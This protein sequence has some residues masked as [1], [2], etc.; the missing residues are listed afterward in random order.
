M[1]PL[2]EVKS[3]VEILS[4]YIKMMKQKTLQTCRLKHSI[5]KGM[6]FCLGQNWN[7]LSLAGGV[8]APPGYAPAFIKRR[9]SHSQPIDLSMRE[10]P[11]EINPL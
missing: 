2:S 1:V 9:L 3:Y 5:K 8:L 6:F 4:F 7:Y 11:L 10:A